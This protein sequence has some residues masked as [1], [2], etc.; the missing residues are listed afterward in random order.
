MSKLMMLV[1]AKWREFSNV[2]PHLQAEQSESNE[3]EYSKPS[4]SRTSKENV[5]VLP[6]N[7][8]RISIK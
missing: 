7:K 6:E 4:R 5:K 3:T 2:N 8:H 1:A